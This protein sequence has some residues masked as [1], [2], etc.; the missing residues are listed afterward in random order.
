MRQKILVML[1]LFLIAMLTPVSAAPI[2]DLEALDQDI[3]NFLDDLAASQMADSRSSAA[4]IQAIAGDGFVSEEIAAEAAAEAVARGADPAS[5]QTDPSTADGVSDFSFTDFATSTE[6]LSASGGIIVVLLLALLFIRVRRR[7]KQEGVTVTAGDSKG[8]ALYAEEKKVEHSMTELLKRNWLFAGII[9]K[10]LGEAEQR[11]TKLNKH[12]DHYIMV[13]K[14]HAFP[15]DIFSFKN[16][17]LEQR[18]ANAELQKETGMDNAQWADLKHFIISMRDK[19]LP[20]WGGPKKFHLRKSDF[21]NACT[22]MS[23]LRTYQDFMEPVAGVKGVCLRIAKRLDQEKRFIEKMLKAEQ[24]PKETEAIKQVMESLR[25]Q[26]MIL[27]SEMHLIKFDEQVLVKMQKGE[28]VSRAEHH[29]SLIPELRDYQHHAKALKDEHARQQDLLEKVYE[30]QELAPR[31]LTE[32]QIRLLPPEQVRGYVV[33]IA[34]KI[35]ELTSVDE[36]NI[37]YVLKDKPWTSSINDNA[38]VYHIRKKESN[39]P[40]AKKEVA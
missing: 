1:V 14:N 21:N 23:E 40:E 6:G 32:K 31:F 12:Y 35:G 29:T 39:K 27:K 17:P 4:D 22:I 5:L 19:V 36:H 24:D 2:D 10:K 3:Q 15:D 25:K 20:I 8:K 16:E 34:G 11:I 30:V 18:F 7:R 13:L 37:H 28:S 9:D 38:K 33:E 26:F